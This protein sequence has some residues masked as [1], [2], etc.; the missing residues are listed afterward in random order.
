MTLAQRVAQTE[1]ELAARRQARQLSP[2]TRALID[3]YNTAHPLHAQFARYRYRREGNR[4]KSRYQHAESQGATV[5][6]PDGKTWASF[7]SSDADAGVGNRPA[8]RSSQ[9]ACWGDSFALFVHYEH[10]GY[11]RAALASLKVGVAV[12]PPTAVG[13]QRADEGGRDGR[14]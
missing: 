10:G 8:R 3:G 6:L 9:A 7:S 13:P 5:I 4:F 14:V 1:A 2:E 12:G 11:F